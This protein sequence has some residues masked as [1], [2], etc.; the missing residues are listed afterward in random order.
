MNVIVVICTNDLYQVK[1]FY[2]FRYTRMSPERFDHLLSLVND[3]LCPKASH[4]RQCISSEGKLLVTLRYLASG[5]SQQ[6]QSFSFQLGKSTVS[7]I[8]KQTCNA[9]WERLS[10][11]YMKFPSTLEEWQQISAE[12]EQ[13]WDFPHVIGALDGKK[14]FAMTKEFTYVIN[15]AHIQLL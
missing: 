10:G 8:V 14:S 1:T 15:F 11:T 13:Q 5:D 3:D 9:L 7:K 4:F 12:Y 6:S 2:F